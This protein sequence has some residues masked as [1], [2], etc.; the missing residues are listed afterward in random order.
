[1]EGSILYTVQCGDLV[2]AM[3]QNCVL[4]FHIAWKDTL[5]GFALVLAVLV[6]E[7]LR[8]KRL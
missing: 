8:R 2:E 4:G 3:T 5:W 1:M 6:M 7:S